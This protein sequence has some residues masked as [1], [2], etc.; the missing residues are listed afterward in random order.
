MKKF[1]RLFLFVFVVVLL[2]ACSPAR[3]AVAP[4]MQ[5][6]DEGRMLVLILLTAAVT[7]LLLKLSEILKVDLS[8]HAN[9]V[10]AAIAPILVT[11]IES[12]L[13]LIP[14]AFDNIVLTIIHLLVLLV[15]SLGSIWLA[16][17]KPAPSLRG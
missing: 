11:V 13:Q 6:P 7:W 14:P 2:V 10:A 3:S 15:G 5:L 17:R 9:A 8:G 12:W 16:Q 4:L 1:G